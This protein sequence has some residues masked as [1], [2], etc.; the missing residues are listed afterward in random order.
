MKL[1]K[2]SKDFRAYIKK[3]QQKLKRDVVQAYGGCCV[4][5][6]ERE[7]V[8]L[9]VDHINGDG[10]KHREKVGSGTKFYYWLKRNKYPS[11]FQI[12]CMNCQFGI[13]YGHV[14]PHQTK[15]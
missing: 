8:F 2:T 1:F 11:S 3:Q 13:R 7:I 12:L 5:C 14:C 6:E 9:S 10:N 15:I 4:C